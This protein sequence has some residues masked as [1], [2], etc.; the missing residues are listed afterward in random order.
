MFAL[1]VAAGMML[2]K[3]VLV[4]VK[5]LPLLLLLLLEDAEL[6]DVVVVMLLVAAIAGEATSAAM[7]SA[8]MSSKSS[9]AVCPAFASAAC[10]LSFL[11]FF[12]I[13]SREVVPWIQF[14][15]RIAT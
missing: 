2:E 11:L 3:E 7:T 15:S 6:E 12:G 5:V 9:S 4:A 13:L 1:T 8:S 10:R 14:W